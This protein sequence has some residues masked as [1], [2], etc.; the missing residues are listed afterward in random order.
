MIVGAPR[1]QHTRVHVNPDFD[2]ALWY[3]N[4]TGWAQATLRSEG[5]S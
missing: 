4:V 3:N 1:V 5:H 2:N